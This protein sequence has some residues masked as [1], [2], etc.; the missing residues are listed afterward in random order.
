MAE[1]NNTNVAVA[2]VSFLI[3]I[4]GLVA[5]FVKKNETPEAAKTYLGCAGAGFVFALL[6]LAAM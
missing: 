4:V 1:N 3:P 6:G 2:I 5:Y